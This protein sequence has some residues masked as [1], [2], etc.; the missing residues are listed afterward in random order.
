ME[1]KQYSH[2][3]KLKLSTEALCMS[4]MFKL[5]VLIYTII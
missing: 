2:N 5:K 1:S 4:K 3:P